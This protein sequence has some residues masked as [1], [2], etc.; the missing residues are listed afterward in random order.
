M[1]ELSQRCR[2]LEFKSAVGAEDAAGRFEAVSAALNQAVGV[3]NVFRQEMAQ[4]DVIIGYLQ[5][6]MAGLRQALAMAMVAAP[7]AAGSLP[8]QQQ[9]AQQQVGLPVVTTATNTTQPS[10]RPAQISTMPI[11]LPIQQQPQQ[12]QEQQLIS[13][14][15][16]ASLAAAPATAPTTTTAAGVVG[17]K[18]EFLGAVPASYQPLT[19]LKPPETGLPSTN[20]AATAV[21]ASEAA[22]APAPAVIPAAPEVVPYN[23]KDEEMPLQMSSQP[24]DTATLALATAEA[25]GTPSLAAGCPK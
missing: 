22:T 7:N 4:R 17:D 19:P 25:E 24:L 23:A 11:S 3:T 15:P 21:P 16:P 1:E 10:L 13:G 2:E 14:L 5:R 8:Q 20:G 9:Q 12:Q 6:E 18:G